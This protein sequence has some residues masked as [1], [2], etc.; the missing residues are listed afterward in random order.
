MQPVDREGH[1]LKLK[2]NVM[3]TTEG[4]QETPGVIRGFDDSTGNP[5]VVFGTHADKGTAVMIHRV[6]KR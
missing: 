6:V 1:P 2:D 5:I 4:G 3:V